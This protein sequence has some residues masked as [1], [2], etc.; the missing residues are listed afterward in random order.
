MSSQNGKVQIYWKIKQAKI[1]KEKVIHG[2]LFS[3]IRISIN[4]KMFCMKSRYS[5]GEVTAHK[6]TI[7]IQGHNI[8]SIVSH[9]CI[10]VSINF[11]IFWIRSQYIRYGTSVHDSNIP[12]QSHQRMIYRKE[13]LSEVQN[14]QFCCWRHIKC[15]YLH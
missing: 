14:L 7:L 3:S 10:S 12:I 5:R 8:W 1:P 15:L 2:K 13:I 9:V 6:S 11:T 4:F